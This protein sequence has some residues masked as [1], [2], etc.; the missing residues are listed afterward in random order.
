MTWRLHSPR[1]CP[2]PLPP[3][4]THPPTLSR[5][6]TLQFHSCWRWRWLESRSRGR[7]SDC[8]TR[9]RSPSRSG[10][11]AFRSSSSRSRSYSPAPG[12]SSAASIGVASHS[13]S[14][15]ASCSRIHFWSWNASHR[16]H[17][18]RRIGGAR[19]HAAGVRRTVV[20][21]LAARAADARP[22]DRHRYR[23]VRCARRRATRLVAP[24]GRQPGAPC[25]AICSRSS[26]RRPPPSM[27]SPAVVCARR[28]TSGRTWRSC[29]AAASSCCS[30]SPRAVDAPV[31][32]A[33]AARVDD[34]RRPGDR[35]DAA[36][37]HGTELGAQVSPAYVVNLTLLGEPVG[38]TIIAAMLPAS[39]RSRA[40]R[41]RRR[42]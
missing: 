14:P 26:A 24:T 41:P 16:Y 8:R 5:P 7:S 13:P 35:P 37:P 12:G 22:V 31:L 2:P 40:S 19:E 15:P 42:R 38:A 29:T 10:A 36:R 4:R 21:R 3:P 20:R 1:A 39:A 9:I 30:C 18:R 25:S 34:F 11:S 17:D 23:H 33:A 27:S 32:A 6:G 28:S